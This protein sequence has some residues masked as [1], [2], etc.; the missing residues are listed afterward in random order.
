MTEQLQTTR[1]MDVLVVNEPLDSCLRRNDGVHRQEPTGRAA[2][3]MVWRDLLFLHW[4]VE[5]AAIKRLLPVGLDV[6]IFDGQAWIGLVPF[7]MPV[8]RL[9]GANFPGAGSVLEC[10]VRTYVRCGNETGVWFFTLDTDS[11]SAVLGARTFWRLNYRRSRITMNRCA[12]TIDYAV[13][14]LD[15]HKRSHLA[16][17]YAPSNNGDLHQNPSL[18]CAWEIG[19]EL[20][21]SQPGELAH[22][23]TERYALFTVG[24]RGQIQVSRI[25]HEPWRLREAR[26]MELNDSLVKAAGV[27]IELAPTNPPMAFCS[28]HM[29]VRAWPFGAG[30]RFVRISQRPAQEND[31][32][33]AL[34]CWLSAVCICCKADRMVFSTARGVANDCLHDARLTRGP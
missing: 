28:D 32:I 30:L 11:T 7:A 22:F 4:P 10:N 26:V 9:Y 13:E 14:R 27:E 21:A 17:R 23:L 16:Q 18:R 24:R 5:P 33:F 8:V 31:G 15:H 29:D 19:R 1:S 2:V 3:R 34:I 25:H 6:D 12:N 20:P